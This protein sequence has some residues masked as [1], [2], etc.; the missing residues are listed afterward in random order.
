MDVDDDVLP[1]IDHFSQHVM[2]DVHDY[3]RK[4]SFDGF[5]TYVAGP[6]EGLKIQGCQYYLMG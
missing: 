1:T 4:C 6:S 5:V 3:P 2:A